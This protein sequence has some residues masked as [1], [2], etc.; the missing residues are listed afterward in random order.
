M[1]IKEIK[2]ATGIPERTLKPDNRLLVQLGL[3]REVT[4]GYRMADGRWQPTTYQLLPD[5]ITNRGQDAPSKD[6]QDVGFGHPI[7]TWVQGADTCSNRGQE[8][9]EN[10]GGDNIIAMDFPDAVVPKDWGD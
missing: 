9:P 1:S 8:N 10:Q 3:I 5:T 2:R 7:C 4:K 6:R